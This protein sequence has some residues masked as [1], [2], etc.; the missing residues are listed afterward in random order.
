MICEYLGCKKRIGRSRLICQ[1][2]TMMKYCRE[3]GRIVKYFIDNIQADK[4]V[5]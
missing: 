1:G 2:E 4:G 5:D 3:H